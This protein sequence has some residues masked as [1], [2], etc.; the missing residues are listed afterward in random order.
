MEHKELATALEDM[1]LRE[2]KELLEGFMQHPVTK[3]LWDIFRAQSQARVPECL[4]QLQTLEDAIPKEFVKGEISALEVII[5]LPGLLLEE[6]L[7][8]IKLQKEEDEHGNDE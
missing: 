5:A 3:R 8:N 2:Q 7:Q 4:R 6:T 1:P